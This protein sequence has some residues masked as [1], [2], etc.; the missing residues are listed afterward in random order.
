[1]YKIIVALIFMIASYTIEAQVKLPQMSPKSTL[2]QTVGL[3]DIDIEYHRPSAKGRVV[4]GG[5]VPFDKVWRTGANENTTI[6]FTDDVVINGSP[7]KQGKYAIYTIP[8]PDIWEVIFYSDTNN[9]GNPEVWDES[10]IVLKVNAKPEI[11]A[12]NVETFTIGINNTDSNFANLEISWEK[13]IVPLKIE[14]PTQKLTMSSIDKTLSGPSAADYYSS[15]Q[16]FFQSN[17]D[18]NKA[19]SYV[20]KAYDLND[21]KPYWYTR[22]KSQ[23]QAKLGDK[24]G[25]IETAKSSLAGAQAAKNEDYVKMNQD[26]IA[27]WSKK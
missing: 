22:L 8:K 12:R 7:L 23:I 17:G 19:L 9:W 18:L 16:Y 6:T 3:T 1:M 15:A 13:T 27:D 25:A 4:F 2:I 21:K 26:S 10:K 11:L 14:V 24:K 5:L 20:N